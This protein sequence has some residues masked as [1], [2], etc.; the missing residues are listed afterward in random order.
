L[1]KK[2]ELEG[3]DAMSTYEIKRWKRL[4]TLDQIREKNLSNVAEKG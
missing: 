1:A 3:V 2:F 4:I